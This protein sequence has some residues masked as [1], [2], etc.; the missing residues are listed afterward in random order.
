MIFFL[1]I[2]FPGLQDPL[3]LEALNM[4]WA[5]LEFLKIPLSFKQQLGPIKKNMYSTSVQYMHKSASTEE[6]LLICKK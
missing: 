5:N 4:S 1:Q 6:Y 2:A 3:A